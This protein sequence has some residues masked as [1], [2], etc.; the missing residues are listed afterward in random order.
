M[1]SPGIRLA[2]HDLLVVVPFSSTGSIPTE[3]IT[4]GDEPNLGEAINNTREEPDL[5]NSA[6][7]EEL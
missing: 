7:T 1:F 4:T 2:I 5:C 3:Y 6:I